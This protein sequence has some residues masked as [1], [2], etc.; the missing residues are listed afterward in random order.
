[1]KDVAC[2]TSP[3]GNRFFYGI[4][5]EHV[6]LSLYDHQVVCRCDAQ[7]TR[8]LVD[9]EAGLT[10]HAETQ[11]APVPR[12]RQDIAHHS[13]SQPLCGFATGHVKNMDLD[14]LDSCGEVLQAFL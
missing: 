9:Q 7:T 6:A 14:K 8:R 11:K 12:K 10:K 1:M 5:G 3:D 13:Q 2:F 4:L